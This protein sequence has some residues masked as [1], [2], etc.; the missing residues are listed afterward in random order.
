MSETEK[1]THKYVG[2]GFIPGVPA[3]DLTQEDL[4]GF[5]E[6]TMEMLRQDGERE[7]PAFKHTK[8]L[9]HSEA[10]KEAQKREKADK[11]TAKKEG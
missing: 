4:D 1:T 5:D 7:A 11:A 2:P 8:N 6:P 3:R 9:G 10:Y